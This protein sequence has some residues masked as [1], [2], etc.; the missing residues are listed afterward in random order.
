MSFSIL[1]VV[2]HL[3]ANLRQLL[4]DEIY[5]KGRVVVI[6]VGRVDARIGRE[7]EE[8]MIALAPLAILLQEEFERNALD[9]VVSM[10]LADSPANIT[11]AVD[12][13][14]KITGNLKA[15]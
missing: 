7:E 10:T 15:I 4:S 6:E 8:S 9:V 11:K 5:G 1:S 14:L 13:V 2:H 12:I 3:R